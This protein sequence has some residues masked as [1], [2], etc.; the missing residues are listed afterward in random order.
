MPDHLSEQGKRKDSDGRW[1]MF[2]TVCIGMTIPTVIFGRATIM[3]FLAVSVLTAIFH[4]DVQILPL[5]RDAFRRNRWLGMA[6]AVTAFLWL[7]SSFTSIEVVKSL[8]TWARTLAIASL[9]VVFTAYL[10]SSRERLDLALK[11]LIF[12]SF[13]ILTFYAVFSL[14]IHP[15]PFE[16]FRLIK[17][18]HSILMQN[19]KPYYS[20]A[21]CILPVIVWAGFRLGSVYKVLSL[22]SIPL[23]LLLIYAKGVQP[24]LSALIGLCAS[25]LAVGFVFALKRMTIAQTRLLLV[26][27]FVVAIV[28]AV[29]VI[30]GLPAP[31][32]K[33]NQIP[34]LPFPDWHRQVIWGYT[35]DVI[36]SAPALGVGPNAINLLPGANVYIPGMNQEYIPSHPHNWP[37]EIAA[38]TGL[39]GLAAFLLAFFLAAKALVANAI[40]NHTGALVATALFAV[41]WVSS[42]ANF[43]I[44]AS[45]WLTVFAVLV[46]FPLAAI[47]AEQK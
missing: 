40:R 41:F 4:K 36:K 38:E 33:A 18:P 24:G 37:L 16:I 45:W 7:I 34:E 46:S 8:G 43:S 30:S 20:V 2:A 47:V 27:I 1:T 32:V 6:A 29:Y 28:G 17:G 15:A 25:V 26:A 11:S 42:L 19:L 10:A 22:L 31:P 21:A 35:V 12:T 5:A 23:T 14:Y 44:W 3:P 39:I 9:A 13:G